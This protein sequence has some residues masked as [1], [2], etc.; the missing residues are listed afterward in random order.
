MTLAGGLGGLG[1]LYHPAFCGICTYKPPAGPPSGSVRGPAASPPSMMNGPKPSTPS[2]LAGSAASPSAILSGSLA[3]QAHS[4]SIG[5]SSSTPLPLRQSPPSGLSMGA[6]PSTSLPVGQLPPVNLSLGA[7]LPASFLSVTSAPSPPSTATST[8]PVTS[9][10]KKPV[11][12]PAST[13]SFVALRAQA[14]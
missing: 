7:H 12:L 9:S 8:A 14:Y 6:S 10:I 3:S 1:P 11:P 5:P 13:A 2:L 4:L